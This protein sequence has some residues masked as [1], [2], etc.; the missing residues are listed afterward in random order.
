MKIL[1]KII[2]IVVAIILF[3]YV[4]VYLGW[5]NDYSEGERTGDVFKFS[6]KGL[7][8]KSWEGELYL[9]GLINK[10]R[11]LELEKFYFSIPKFQEKEKFEL[12]EKLKQCSRQRLNCTINYKQWLKRPIYQESGYTVEDI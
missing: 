1:L 10:G 7:I 8:W 11:N 2:I 3:L 4:V 5:V 12:I 9:G 6:Q